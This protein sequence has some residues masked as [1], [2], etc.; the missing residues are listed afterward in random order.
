MKPKINLQ[1]SGH[2]KA[3]AVRHDGSRRELGAW[4]DNMILNTGLDRLGAEASWLEC[5]VGSGTAE[6]L[7]ND[8]A[9]DALEA[10]TD[11]VLSTVGG[12]DSAGEDPFVWARRVFRFPVGAVTATLS[13]VGVGWDGG[14]FSRALIP[15]PVEVLSD[16]ALEMT[17]EVRAFPTMTDQVATVSISAVD[18]EFTFRPAFFGG[19]HAE[20]TG[21]PAQLISIM[22]GGLTQESDLGMTAYGVGAAFG[23]VDEGIVGTELGEGAGSFNT[24]YVAAS[25][26]RNCRMTFGTA[27]GSAS[28]GAFELFSPDGCYQVLVD[29]PI[30]KTASNILDLDFKLQWAR[31][32][33]EPPVDFDGYAENFTTMITGRGLEL[34]PVGDVNTWT[35][36]AGAGGHIVDGAYAV[37]TYTGIGTNCTWTEGT[38]SQPVNRLDFR[39]LVTPDNFDYDG[40]PNFADFF[41]YLYGRGTFGGL[42][43]GVAVS[44]VSIGMEFTKGSPPKVRYSVSCASDTPETSEGGDQQAGY[45]GPDLDNPPSMTSGANAPI[46]VYLLF[47]NPNSMQLY[48]DDVLIT[49][50]TEFTLVDP[51]PLEMYQIRMYCSPGVN[52]DKISAI[53]EV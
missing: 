35:Q 48:V 17:Y 32:G 50:I 43:E 38:F 41:I 45:L 12:T 14:L 29:P 10:T 36:H 4:F 47:N 39:L 33:D 37:N 49:T 19:T 44:K 5:S 1:V 26:E 6:A 42:D 9:L 18:Y 22:D 8:T 16:E 34:K 52:V 21:W 27:A 11:V 46:D 51:L 30:P 15:A 24:N 20:P 53:N 23:D 7:E 25:Y 13:E 3:E 31:R 2:Y 40:N 28:F